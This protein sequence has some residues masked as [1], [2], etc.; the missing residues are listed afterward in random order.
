MRARHRHLKSKSLGA[1]VCLD[2]RY[3]SASNGDSVQTWSDQ[4]GNSRDAAQATSASRPTFVTSASGGQP[5]LN[6]NAQV[7]S[8]ASTIP[9]TRP[10]SII[11]VQWKNASGARIVSLSNE[12]ARGINSNTYAATD[13]SDGTIYATGRGIRG[14]S[15]G[16]GNFT[17][18]TIFSTITDQLDSVYVNG[19]QRTRTQISTIGENDNFDALGRVYFTSNQNNGRIA[20]VVAISENLTD[21]LRKRLEHSAAFA[22]K[23]SCN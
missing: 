9:S 6:F 16:A 14:G 18:A 15:F 10:V 17:S 21:A 7:M 12:T 4:S 3:V 20:F 22:W 19:S 2:A 1:T 5:A 11:A 13:W 8:F 23:I